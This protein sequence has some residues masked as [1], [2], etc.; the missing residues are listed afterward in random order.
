MIDLKSA[1]IPAA[2]S[3]E[4]ASKRLFDNKEYKTKKWTV[5]YHDRHVGKLEQIGLTYNLSDTPGVI[6][7]PPLIVGD[8]TKEILEELGY[9]EADILS[10]ANETAILCDPPVPGQKEMK[11][12]WGL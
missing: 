11:N 9:T 2:I 4:N 3:D 12:P 5:E 8:C 6:S 10:M 7:R 1:G